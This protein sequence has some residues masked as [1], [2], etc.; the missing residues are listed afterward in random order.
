MERGFQQIFKELRQ[1]KGL[2][3][4][5]LAE[6]LN[7]TQG[8]ISGWE[9]GTVEPKATALI[10]IALYFGVTIEYLL[11]VSDEFNTPVTAPINDN[12]TAKERELLD[13]FRTLTPYLQELALVTVRGFAGNAGGDGLHKKA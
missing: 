6:R 10:A 1:E 8:N 9:N 2:T 12:L 4:A 7:Y 3:Q 13:T 11:G 5:Q